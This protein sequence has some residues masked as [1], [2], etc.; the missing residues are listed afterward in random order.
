MRH[1]TK[2]YSTSCSSQSLSVM[3]S[4]VVLKALAF[5]V[6]SLVLPKTKNL[7]RTTR[8]QFHVIEQRSIPRSRASIYG[9]T[10]HVTEQ[11]ILELH[12]IDS[13]AARPP[14]SDHGARRLAAADDRRRAAG[15]PARRPRQGRSH[16]RRGVGNSSV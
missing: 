7:S 9:A 14:E 1:V 12:N 8:T 5:R 15:R 16:V 10:F 13:T 2:Q 6:K 11:R 3:L 4:L